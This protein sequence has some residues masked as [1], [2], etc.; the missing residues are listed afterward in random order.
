MD[1]YIARM[2]SSGTEIDNEMIEALR[3]NYG[4]DKPIY[5]QYFIWFSGL[6]VGD[7][8]W[9]FYHNKP[10]SELVGERL[11]LTVLISIFTLIFTY[12]VA[13]PIGI[14][15]ATRQYSIFDYSFTL[16]GF[17]GLSMPPFLLALILMYVGYQYLGVDVGGLFS[18]EYVGAP[19]SLAKVIDMLGHIWIPVIVVGTAGTA[20]II[21]VMRGCLLDE[22]SKQYVQTARAKGLKENKLIFKYPVRISINPIISTIGWM[23]PQI[24]SGSL[25]VSVV[26]SLPTTGNLLLFALRTQDMYLAGS[27]IMLLSFLTILGTLISDI[28]LAAADPR[29]RLEK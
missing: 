25:I 5:V 3:A 28:L 23:L 11:A 24:I 20:G 7:F 22:L 12:L 21:R 15:S 18:I 17:M 6:F 8:G 14:L 13:V 4:L 29:I 19:W 16:V 1:S 2:Q 26:L 27:M 10:V 9:S